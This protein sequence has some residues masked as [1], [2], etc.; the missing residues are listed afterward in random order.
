MLIR[1]LVLL[2]ANICAKCW[3]YKDGKELGFVPEGVFSLE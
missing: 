2:N 1:Y 3:R